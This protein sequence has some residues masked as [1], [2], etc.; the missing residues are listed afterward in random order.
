MNSIEALD[1]AITLTRSHR[2][3]IGSRARRTGD[4]MLT[5][6]LAHHDAPLQT[7]CAL[8]DLIREQEQTAERDRAILADWTERAG[9][10]LRVEP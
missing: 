3:N 6:C 4:P 2:T 9:A 10:P 5:E 7:L 8:R 1:F